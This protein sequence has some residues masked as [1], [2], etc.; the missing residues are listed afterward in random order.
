LAAADFN[1]DGIPDIV[2]T[3]LSI[4]ADFGEIFVLLGKG[5]REFEKPLH[6][7]SGGYQ[8]LGIAVADLNHDNIPDLVVALRA[9][10][11]SPVPAASM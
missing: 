6:F 1:G 5:N 11:R 10:L 7:A 3:A 8:P 4:G 9:R 2:G